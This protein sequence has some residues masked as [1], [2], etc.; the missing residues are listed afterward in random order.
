MKPAILYTITKPPRFT[1]KKNK[2]LFCR[3]EFIYK[4]TYKQLSKLILF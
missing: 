1:I 3:E 2:S 4:Y